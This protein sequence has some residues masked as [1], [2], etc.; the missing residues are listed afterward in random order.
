MVGTLLLIGS[1]FKEVN[2]MK[3]RGFRNV[4]YLER[5]RIVWNDR[6]TVNRQTHIKWKWELMK[7]M[8]VLKRQMKQL[9]LT[10]KLQQ[11]LKSISRQLEWRT[12]CN[13]CNATNETRRNRKAKQTLR[14]INRI[15][16]KILVKWIC[17]Y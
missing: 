8:R 2:K 14:V 17:W 10:L 9:I 4:K 11:E 7:I 12:V 1:P 5:N 16:T 15:K 13:I 6:G 3:W